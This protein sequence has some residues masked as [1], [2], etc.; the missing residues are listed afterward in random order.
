MKKNTVVRW[1]GTTAVSIALLTGS[2]IGFSGCSPA[3]NPPKEESKEAESVF[4]YEPI[5]LEYVKDHYEYFTK[6]MLLCDLN[7]DKIPELFS[8]SYEVDGTRMM[9]HEL[10][11]DK[12]VPKQSVTSYIN[13]D[14]LIRPTTFFESPRYFLGIYENKT[15]G[16]KA[17][18]NSYA[19][20]EDIFDIITYQDDTVVI[21]HEG[22]TDPTENENH[23]SKRDQIMIQY[24]VSDDSLEYSYLL[25]GEFG[26]EH[27]NDPAYALQETIDSF[28]KGPEEPK[29]APVTDGKI[30]CYIRSISLSDK[31]MVL[32]PA[33]YITY[34]DYLNAKENGEFIVLNGEDLSLQYDETVAKETGVAGLHQMPYSS[35]YFDIPTKEFPKSVIR[36]YLGN[37][38]IKVK[39]NENTKIIDEGYDAMG[40]GK[41]EYTVSEYLPHYADYYMLNYCEAL[42][43][44]NE[45]VSLKILYH[46]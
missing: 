39:L 35:Y 6:G 3:Q 18:I 12:L 38:P 37:T 32:V 14:N 30:D 9:Y 31:E 11:D 4:Q 27:G 42:I 33:A 36:G 19:D 17:L 44:N 40:R 22:V 45:V 16:Q 26:G 7:D 41:P 29:Y 24:E 23:D 2:L 43:E 20:D 13:I 21:A 5:Y 10:K 15:T 25:R 8:I 1:I 46:P 34:E 28:K